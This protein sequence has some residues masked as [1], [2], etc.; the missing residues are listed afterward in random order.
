M[1]LKLLARTVFSAILVLVAMHANAAP[2]E[3][4]GTAGATMIEVNGRGEVLW[5]R[6]APDQ[7]PGANVYVTRKTGAGY[8]TRLINVGRE[9]LAYGWGA[10]LND[11]GDSVWVENPNASGRMAL[12]YYRSSTGVTTRLADH[13][14]YFQSALSENG[15]AAWVAEGP[16]PYPGYGA[17]TNIIYYDRATGTVSTLSATPT[18]HP[19]VAL[20][21]DGNAYWLEFNATTNALQL[22]KYQYN[23]KRTSTLNTRPAGTGLYPT[24]TIQVSEFGDVAWQELSASTGGSPDVMI[25]RARTSKVV[26]ATNSV[27]EEGNLRFNSVGDLVFG[28]FNNLWIHRVRTGVTELVTNQNQ[29][30]S[31]DVSDTGDVVWTRYLSEWSFDL[32]L[33]RGATGESSQ[34]LSAAYNPRAVLL[35]RSGDLYF[36]S[37]VIYHMQE[38][39]CQ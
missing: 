39:F 34:I 3:I 18:A 35:S 2:T 30:G 32:M 36:T 8:D 21:R 4:P 11:A 38:G 12:Y 33:H 23:N 24:P 13:V 26:R 15:N 25:Y 6:G 1:G 14:V 27:A 16:S 31:A 22:R 17:N 28:S 29:Y 5:A 9:G 37:G 20:D 10:H 19:G 7:G